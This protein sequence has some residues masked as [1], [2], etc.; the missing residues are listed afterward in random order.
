MTPGTIGEKIQ[1]SEIPETSRQ[2]ILELTIHGY[3]AETVSQVLGAVENYKSLP[4]IPQDPEGIKELADDAFA[5]A[6]KGVKLLSHLLKEG[7]IL[8]KKQY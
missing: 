6:V 7:L 5:D 1:A 2:P 8:C 3:E 4:D